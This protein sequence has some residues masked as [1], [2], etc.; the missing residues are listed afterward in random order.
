M[1]G[2]KTP[3]LVSICL[4]W[5]ASPAF[6][7]VKMGLSVALPLDTFH[8]ALLLTFSS[9][10]HSEQSLSYWKQIFI[11][12]PFQRSPCSARYSHCFCLVWLS[13]GS[14]FFS[15]DRLISSLC[16]TSAQSKHRQ[17]ANALSPVVATERSWKNP[18]LRWEA[19]P[20]FFKH[21]ID[22]ML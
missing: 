22:N 16:S 10:P 6:T 18:S 19:Q 5:W 15:A 3:F 1:C 7:F 20:M 13:T 17:R 14:T 2:G 11:L 12:I 4:V 9:P 21:I 8:T